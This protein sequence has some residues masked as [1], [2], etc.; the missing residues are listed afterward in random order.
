MAARKKKEKIAILGAGPSALVAAMRLTETK[1][2]RD[3]YDITIYQQGWRVGGKCATGRDLDKH[4]RVYEHG[5]HGFLGCYFNALTVMQDAFKELNRKKSHPLPTFEQAFYGMSGVIRYEMVDGEIKKWPIRVPTNDKHREDLSLAEVKRLARMDAY[6]LNMIRLGLGFILQA[7]VKTYRNPVT[8]KI[9][10]ETFETPPS[11]GKHPMK[12]DPAE[13]AYDLRLE[14]GKEEVN[15]LLGGALDV[16]LPHYGPLAKAKKIDP[17]KLEVCMK[18]AAASFN[19]LSAL[20]ANIVKA[21]GGASEAERDRIRRAGLALNFVA[22]ILTGVLKDDLLYEP[23]STIDDQE[24][25]K[26]LKKH[27]ATDE[28][29]NSPLTSSTPNITYQ[30]PMGDSIRLPTM[31]AGAYLHW[32]MMTFTYMGEFIQLFEAGSGETLIAPM[33]E[34]LVKRGVKF[35]FFHTITDIRCD[36]KANSISEFDVDV[37]VKV[38]KGAYKYDPYVKVKGLD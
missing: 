31:A 27:G 2:L 38:K 20:F 14:D 35:A 5:I 30:Y 18:T 10:A 29:I 17:A 22:A 19:K 1:A 28:T 34:V 6:S 21:K 3:R 11:D 36:K 32:T 37:Q 8:Q 25:W 26:W 23:F 9:I 7:Y 33:H 16:I 4:M 15:A 12:T 24:H 13:G